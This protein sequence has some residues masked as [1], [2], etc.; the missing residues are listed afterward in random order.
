MTRDRE[1]MP[2]TT[3]PAGRIAG[4]ISAAYEYDRRIANLRHWARY[5]E[6]A[7][8]RERARRELLRTGGGSW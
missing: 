4:G 5:G 8:S 2:P 1:T 6:P 7:E 3:P